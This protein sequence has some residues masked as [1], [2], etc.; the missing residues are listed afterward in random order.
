MHNIDLLAYSIKDE[1][2]KI[3]KR[4]SRIWEELKEQKVQREELEALIERVD[5]LTKRLKTAN[6]AEEKAVS[7]SKPI[8]T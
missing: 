1:F 7:D 5:L 8:I 3:N 2:N 4:L 6:D